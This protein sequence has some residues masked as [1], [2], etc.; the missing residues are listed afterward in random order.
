[1]VFSAFPAHPG[2][3]IIGP[4]EKTAQTGLFAGCQAT[5]IKATILDESPAKMVTTRI[6]ALASAPRPR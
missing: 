4:H 6:K 5:V 1:M 2:W 3:F